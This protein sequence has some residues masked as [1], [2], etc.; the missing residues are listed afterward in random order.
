[1]LINGWPAFQEW[2]IAFEDAEITRRRL[3][4][5]AREWAAHGRGKRHLLDKHSLFEAT[6]WLAGDDAKIIGLDPLLVDHVHASRASQFFNQVK[7]AGVSCLVLLLTLGAIC[8]WLFYGE[9]ARVAES[10]LLAARALEAL[11][12]GNLNVALT[13]GIRAGLSY[14]TYEA[15]NS[16]LTTL[17]NNP[18]S[19][20]FLRGHV[21]LGA[22]L[23]FSPDGDRI[24]TG[25]LLPPFTFWDVATGRRVV[26]GPQA[27]ALGSVH[28]VAF[29]P[30]GRHIALGGVEGGTGTIALWELDSGN[31]TAV[32]NVAGADAVHGLAFRH[33]GKESSVLVSLCQ[34]GSLTVWSVP[35]LEVRECFES[36]DDVISTVATSP[37]GPVLALGRKSGSLRLHRFEKNLPAEGRIFKDDHLGEVTSLAF[38]P[39]GRTLAS[40]FENRKVYL[41][42]LPKGGGLPPEGYTPLIVEG[43]AGKTFCLAFSADGRTLALNSDNEIRFCNP[44]TGALRQTVLRGHAVNLC[45]LAISPNGSHLASC[46]R[47][48]RLS[49]GVSLKERY[50]GT[51][52][53]WNLEQ[54]PLRRELRGHKAR[55]ESLAFSPDA[56]TL[57][58]ASEDEHILLWDVSHGLPNG[59][60]EDLASRGQIADLSFVK[61]RQ[62]LSAVRKDHSVARWDL[63]TSVARSLDTPVLPSDTTAWAF[64]PDGTILAVSASD[65]TF[66]WDIAGGKTMG[67]PI[68]PRRTTSLA[69]NPDGTALAAA[70]DIGVNV[71]DT[72]TNKILFTD[73]LLL[74]EDRVQG[75]ALSG[76]VERLAIRSLTKAISLK[77]VRSRSFQFN[78]KDLDR[79]K[80]SV[81]C[82]AFSP[83]GRIL[84]S[85]GADRTI[86]LWD[87]EE[88]RQIGPPLTGHEGAVT[89]LAFSP[90]AKTLAS[91]GDDHAVFL[92]DADLGSWISR[93]SRMLNQN[94]SLDKLPERDAPASVLPNT[95]SPAATKF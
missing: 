92:W 13:D 67:N 58:S 64:H 56:K 46:D 20:T 17:L 63:T 42:K 3:E 62:I 66:L 60:V 12:D 47:E 85:A 69:F 86:I 51:I 84:A 78:L 76:G 59:P 81:N 37:A 93:A 43:L 91:G 68:E 38:S 14:D 95:P 23:A 45:S 22:T 89:C 55:I 36:R 94:P 83:D 4:F 53:L 54:P 32:R 88:R 1:M 65:S 11:S 2:L 27:R 41:W 72:A 73:I 26:T 57:A 34:D 75:V 77:A 21:G 24:A 35:A 29:S 79:H 7:F 90:D 40:A 19:P 71:F 87:T 28:S 16:L 52:I 31:L 15:R 80:D 6:R 82:L 30:D 5:K 74:T 25:G 50:G 49:R 33:E 48:A 70:T 9:R 39:D 10:R 44:S 61:D 18:Y 8:G